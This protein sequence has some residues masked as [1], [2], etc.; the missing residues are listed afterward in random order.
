MHL[1]RRISRRALLALVL[2]FTVPAVSVALTSSR[3]APVYLAIGDSLSAGVQPDAHGHSRP[4][5]QGYPEQLAARLRPRNPGLSVVHFG[6]GGTTNT[7]ID[8][9]PGPH[10]PDPALVQAERYLR[11]HRDRVVLIS[12]NIG[13]NDVGECVSAKRID[14]RCVRDQ[15]ADVTRNLPWIVRRLRAASG[16]HVRIVGL[17]DYDQ[18]WA[19]WLRGAAGRAL[20]LRSSAVVARL[21]AALVRTYRRAGA[22]AADAGPRFG[23]TASR[24]LVHLRG[25]GRVPR[26]VER[27]CTLTW[28][29]SRPPIGFNDHANARGYGVLADTMYTALRLAGALPGRP[30]R[31]GG[32]GP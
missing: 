24:P 25:H 13:D 7:L 15:I 8:G 26:A 2:T 27:V 9:A 32:T 31:P 30:G 12:V 20:A 4:T 6:G 14:E 10:A 3:P 23:V 22:V 5:R 28:A 16:G 11:A 19:Y 17:A 18:F 29:C 21:N 1:P